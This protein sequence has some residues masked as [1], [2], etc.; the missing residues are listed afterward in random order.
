MKENNGPGIDQLRLLTDYL[1]SCITDNRNKLFERVLGQR[2]RYISVVLEDI[3][4]SHNASAVLRTCD[5]T[6]IQDIY[7]IENRYEYTLNPDVSLGSA[8]WVNLQKFNNGD[9]GTMECLSHLKAKGYRIIATTPHN[10]DKMLDDLDISQGPFALV[11]GTE[12]KGLSESAIQM[13]D[14]FVKIPMYGF[15]ESYNI[16]VSAALCLF[17]LTEKLRRSGIPWNLTETESLEIKLEWLRTSIRSCDLI[18]KYFYEK[19]LNR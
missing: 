18:E 13:A 2:T 14:E 7:I 12:R 15:T 1:S 17:Y 8:Q 5:C 10:T 16:S 6:G 4:Q 9:N 11:F 3:Y 19:I